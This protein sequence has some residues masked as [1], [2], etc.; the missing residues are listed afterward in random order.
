[1]SRWITAGRLE[2]LA[3]ALEE[4]DGLPVGGLLK[5]QLLDHDLLLALQIEGQIGPGLAARAQRP[6]EHVALL[7]CLEFALLYLLHRLLSAS[8]RH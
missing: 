3:L 4:L 1:M 6:Q 8:N 7:Q 5:A 2:H